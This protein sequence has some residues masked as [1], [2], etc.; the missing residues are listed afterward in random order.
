[1]KVGFEYRLQHQLHCGLH[2]AVSHCRYPQR[3]GTPFGFWDI[4]PPHRIKAIVLASQL[5]LQLAEHLLLFSTRHNAF[6]GFAIHA[7]R[8]P[9]GFYL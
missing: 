5:L 6:D 2:Y 8:T 9:V 7:R 1:M 3:S 4:H